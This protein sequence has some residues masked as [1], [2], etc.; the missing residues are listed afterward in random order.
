V[1]RF[2]VV[3]IAY[4][5]YGYL[6]EA[7]RSV[8]WQTRLPDEVLVFTDN[9]KAV[10]EVLMRH[11]VLADVF[12]EPGLPKPA[13]YAL[14]GE[15]SSADYV[16]P[17]DD[18]D[19]FKRN[20][21]EVLGS[22]LERRRWP[23]VK[24]AVDYMDLSSRP[25]AW[26]DQPA[27]PMVLTCRNVWSI[28]RAVYDMFHAYASSFAVDK[29][30]VEKYSDV[31][32][33]LKLL[34]DYAIFTLGIEERGVLYLPFKLAYYR[35]GAG[36]S[37]FLGCSRLQNLTCVWNKYLHDFAYLEE[38]LKCKT[39]KKLSISNYIAYLYNV[40]LLQGVVKCR[41]YEYVRGTS[42]VGVLCE[43]IR[44]LRYG[45]ISTIFLWLLL[46]TLL[47]DEKIGK[48]HYY[49]LCKST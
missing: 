27:K 36:H 34:D 13:V 20:K 39:V 43:T 17:L 33:R 15:V 48:I 19:V 30:L 32:K 4:R 46:A 41:E 22:V 31:L 6:D 42:I 26:R 12:Y 23:L 3:V 28:Y 7:V 35:I 38:Y 37:Q 16:L 5:R 29:T 49:R 24:H 18:D 47:G 11:G 14:V 1:V 25:I 2:S 21:V 45:I 10:K 8:A 44:A 40:R 9:R